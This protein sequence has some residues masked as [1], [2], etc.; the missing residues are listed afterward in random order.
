MGSK[1]VG[2]GGGGGGDLNEKRG[3]R[4]GGRKQRWCFISSPLPQR[5]Q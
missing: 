4:G 1:V 5:C 3:Q 2:V